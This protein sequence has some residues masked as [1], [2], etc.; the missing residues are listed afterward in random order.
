VDVSLA[1]P[2]SFRFGS[3]TAERSVT[4]KKEIETK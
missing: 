3:E 1:V 2:E 4:G